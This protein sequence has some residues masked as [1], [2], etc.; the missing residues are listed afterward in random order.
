MQRSPEE[1]RH[2][3]E[4]AR[5]DLALSLEELRAKTVELSDWRLQFRRHRRAVLIGAMAAGFVLGGGLAALT[6]WIAGRR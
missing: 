6:N 2:S 3:L 5:R 4:L 1:I